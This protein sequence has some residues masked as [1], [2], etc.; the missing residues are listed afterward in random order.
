MTYRVH[1]KAR[2]ADYEFRVMPGER[3]LHAGLRAGIALPYE[4]GTGTCG[5]CR[6]TLVEGNIRDRWPEAPARRKLAPDGRE[7][8]MCQC[9]VEGDASL[10]L[11]K[12]LP[13]AATGACTPEAFAGMLRNPHRL[14]Q[15]VIAFHVE[16]AARRVFTAGQFMLIESPE[17]PGFRAY[18]MSNHDPGTHT[19]EFVMKRK[20]GGVFSEWL[21]GANR[22]GAPVR[23]FG[24][25]GKATYEPGDSKNILCIAGGSGI[26]GMMAILASAGRAGHFERHEGW[27][28]FGLRTLR[29]AF[30]LQELSSMAKCYPRLAV[31][32][33]FS[34]EE[35]ATGAA[36][37]WSALTF[38]SGLV[39]EVAKRAMA[40]KYANVRAYVAGPPPAVDAAIRLLL[41]DGRLPLGDLRYDKFS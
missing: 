20:P 27:V 22:D 5:T 39:H 8:L 7:I 35:V 3:V 9:S 31:T 2:G 12:T 14:T 34:H 16:T 6:A 30:F 13:T 41:V 19:L 1:L 4:C 37:D 24:P 38:A 36:Y 28:F 15:D 23:L 21:F 32:V 18:S 33:A 40:G 25:L 11:R 17:V 10:E 29:D 26:A